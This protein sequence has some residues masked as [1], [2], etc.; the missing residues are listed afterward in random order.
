MISQSSSFQGEVI[1]HYS[2]FIIH[3]SLLNYPLQQK[4]WQIATVF[5]ISAG[6]ISCGISSQAETW[7]HKYSSYYD[8]QVAK[9]INQTNKPLVISNHSLRLTSLSYL[10]N[11]KIKLQLV[12]AKADA[13]PK[14][15][16]NFTD[17]FIF[18]PEDSF[19]SQLETQANYRLKLIHNFGELWKLVKNQ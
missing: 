1:I 2:L 8:P 5:L 10:L 7:W 4:F 15:S 14:I 19:I 17:I 12:E 9:I 13:L 11:P 16:D 3:Y 6:I 18:N